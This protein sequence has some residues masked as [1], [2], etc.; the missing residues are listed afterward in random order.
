MQ[1]P[2]KLWKTT[3]VIWSKFDPQHVELD[4]LAHEAIRGEAYCNKSL[5]E[6]VAPDN[7]P[8]WDG[9]EFFDDACSGEDTC[10]D[11]PE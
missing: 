5:S 2:N 11:H 4:D 10:V 6:C 1:R 8:D 3:V 9:T 7:D